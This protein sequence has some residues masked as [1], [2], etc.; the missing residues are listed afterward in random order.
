MPQ[1]FPT[2][3]EA[4]NAAQEGATILVASGTY[5]E[6]LQIPKGLTLKGESRETMIVDGGEQALPVITVISPSLVT[7]QG[8]TITQGREGVFVVAGGQVVLVDNQVVQNGRDGVLVAGTAELRDNLI[9]GNGRC[10]VN[11]LRPQARITGSGN[12]VVDNAGGNLCGN[13]N[14][15]QGYPEGFLRQA[16][17]LQV[18]PNSLEFSG[19]IGEPATP[20]QTIRIAN[21]GGS[22]L[23]WT[24]VADAP[25]IQ[26][27][28]TR[29]TLAAG[30]SVEVQVRVVLEGLTV[31]THQARITITAE[32]AL[33][34]PAVVSVTLT[35]AARPAYLKVQP[36]SLVFEGE[37]GGSAPAPQTLI[38]TNTGGQPLNWTA[39]TE[40]SWIA[41]EPNRGALA[42]GQRAE[43]QVAVILGGLGPGRYQGRITIAAPEAENSPVTVSVTLEL[44]AQAQPL[45]ILAID[46]PSQIQADGQP[47]TGFVFFRDPDGDVVQAE[48]RVIEALDLESFTL[49]LQ[50][51]LRGLTEGVFE[52]QI[53]TNTPQRA[54]YEVTLLDAAGN[55]SEPE[56]FSFEA[57]GRPR[58][59]VQPHELSFEGMEGRPN[60]APQTLTIANAGEGLLQWQATADVDWILL[61]ATEGTLM[62]GRSTELRVFASLSGLR[63]GTYKGTITIT[64]PGA[65]GSPAT[66]SVTLT[67]S[68]PPVLEVS[69][70]LLSFRGQEGGANPAP[71]SLQ[72]SNAGGGVLQ[73]RAQADVGWIELSPA[74]GTIAQGQ[75]PTTVR[76]SVATGGLRAGTYQGRITIEAPGARN[77]PVTVQVTLTL[78]E[79][80]PVLQINPASLSF[81]AVSGET[82]SAQTLTVRNAGGGVLVWR[83]TSSVPWITVEPTSGTLSAGSATITVRVSTQGLSVGTHH[84]SIVV[85]AE[86]ALNS[87]QTV[88]V[89][90]EILS[91]TAQCGTVIFADDFSDPDSGW[92]V[93]DFQ[94]AMWSYADDGTYRVLTKW[95]NTI[96]WS[97]APAR[98]LS[99]DFCLAVD[100]K[101]LVAGSLSEQGEI[102]IIFAGDPDAR[103]YN[104]FG[105]RSADKVFRIGRF[106]PAT[107][108]QDIIPP[109]PS[110]AIKTVNN[111]NRL[112]IVAQGG[113]VHFYINDTWVA[114]QTIETSGAVGVFVLTFDAPNVNGRFDNFT[115]QRLKF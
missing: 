85:S 78:E 38:L 54:T 41:L 92:F 105:I 101:Q 39:T 53:A 4:I 106:A 81:R 82:P 102:G 44:R 19:R 15:G 87:P 49:D 1:D 80:R 90:L 75:P 6:N 60:P 110:D 24:A 34:S 50:E 20:A 61:G 108:I 2:I 26:L 48:F 71:Q 33:N 97:W 12:V 31:G 51:Q 98:N 107:W 64:A 57:I 35:L 27:G 40:S 100:V 63:A 21:V 104:L 109:T 65:E 29:G 36:E 114:T 77:S 3:Q 94:G 22:P 28:T 10:G 76:V 30:Q 73:W 62:P 93:G 79:A 74:T 115:I 84:G 11:A 52:F 47:V 18:E 111:F 58:L 59:E 7:I 9:Q 46:F 113:Q 68:R 43:L 16:P 95:D 91:P 42:P 45:E 70:T 83:A 99:G 103:S 72:I 8:F 5:Q 96:A 14:E 23:S 56:R 25:W 69:P 88:A 55:R 112:L 37:V 67:V 89:T 13:P 32:G 17:I 86:G 66:V